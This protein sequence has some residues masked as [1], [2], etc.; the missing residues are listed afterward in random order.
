VPELASSG[1]SPHNIEVA[2]N[3]F[4]VPNLQNEAE[5]SL[6]RLDA[7]RA[8]FS[9][10]ANVA[11]SPIFPS[12]SQSRQ[13]QLI[14]G[15]KIHDILEACRPGTTRHAMP[16][17]LS[18][19]LSLYEV[20][21]KEKLEGIEHMDQKVRGLQSPENQDNKPPVIEEPDD[22]N[23][24]SS[25]LKEWG[26]VD[27]DAVDSI[28]SQS[29]TT[30]GMRR[31]YDVGASVSRDQMSDRS[32]PTSSFSSHL[33][34]LM[35]RSLERA[36]S[37]YNYG[38]GFQLRNRPMVD[39]IQMQ[40]SPSMDS[41]VEVPDE[42]GS[43]IASGGEHEREGRKEDEE[44]TETGFHPKNQV[45]DDAEYLRKLMKQHDKNFFQRNRSSLIEQRTEQLSVLRKSDGSVE[46]E[47]TTPISK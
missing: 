17:A 29:Q 38:G 46:S 21:H 1:L 30:L 4:Y 42:T 26:A 18:S 6:M 45:N 35:S 36:T 47:G 12:K 10:V 2:P 11:A 8:S 34:N 14:S 31:P 22:R 33:S 32:S 9:A 43:G 25:Q 23:P 19:L 3:G 28:L 40:R 41:L 37:L 27:F 20:M 16:S 44:T 7:R 39:G 15:R 13:R 5:Q 24:E